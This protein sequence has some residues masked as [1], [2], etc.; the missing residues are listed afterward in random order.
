MKKN[1]VLFL[2]IIAL[3]FTLNSCSSDDDVSGSNSRRILGKWIPLKHI[4]KSP[5]QPE[6]VTMHQHLCATTKDYYIFNEGG[7][8][9][10]VKYLTCSSSRQENANWSINGNFFI[11]GIFEDGYSYQRAFPILELSSSKLRY[12][13]NYSNDYDGYDIYEFV[14][15]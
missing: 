13:V 4:S 3:T 5:G 1:I 2:S 7:T 9:L 11:L 8:A 12:K 14:R 15:E 6:E 10:A